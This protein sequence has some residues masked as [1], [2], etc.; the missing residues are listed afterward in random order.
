MNVVLN[1][2]K[3]SQPTYKVEVDVNVM[4][5]MRDGVKLATDIYRPEAEGRF[6]AILVRL[7]YGKT[8]AYCEMP[9]FGW[10]FAKRGYVL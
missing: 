3:L 6:P 8:E 7:P 5:P 9:A 2:S 4:V 1:D 10:Y